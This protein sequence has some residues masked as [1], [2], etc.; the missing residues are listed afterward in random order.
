MKNH[1][2]QNEKALC[3]KMQKELFMKHLKP[4]AVIG[5]FTIEVESENPR[6][7]DAI[8]QYKKEKQPMKELF[9]KMYSM[10][11]KRDQG[12][13]KLRDTVNDLSDLVA[14]LEDEKN[15]LEKKLKISIHESDCARG[16]NRSLRAAMEDLKKTVVSDIEDS[17]KL[18]IDANFTIA[19]KDKTIESLNRVIKNGTAQND[20]LKKKAED[21]SK[22][23]FELFTRNKKLTT[24]LKK[25]KQIIKDPV[26]TK[27]MKAERL[28]KIF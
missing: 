8:N 28:N 23:N 20:E 5:S 1:N 4:G 16:S 6:L 9:E 12:I 26:L 2:Y 10:I 17:N 24:A 19:E 27:E 13:E 3:P 25:I 15:L 18:L 22:E 7:M 21:V 14:D 11:E